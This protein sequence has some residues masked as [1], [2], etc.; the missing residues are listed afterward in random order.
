VVT[1]AKAPFPIVILSVL[2]IVVLSIFFG[3]YAL[4]GTVSEKREEIVVHLDLY[5][6][7]NWNLTL[8]NGMDD[9]IKIIKISMFCKG[10]SVNLDVSTHIYP[11]NSTVFSSTPSLKLLP[12]TPSEM[13]I[14][15]LSLSYVYKNKIQQFFTTLRGIY[16]KK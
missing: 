12:G 7:G 9:V 2:V 4:A 15:Q 3:L 10:Y 1:L 6:D 11:G 14:V 5:T 13:Y 16:L 8:K